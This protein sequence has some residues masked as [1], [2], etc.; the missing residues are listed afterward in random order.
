MLKNF[1]RTA[2]DVTEVAVTKFTETEKQ[3]FVKRLERQ[4]FPDFKLFPLSEAYAK[5]K[6]AAEL[7]T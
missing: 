5:R 4:Q 3:A 7:D 6:R 2:Y 1:Q